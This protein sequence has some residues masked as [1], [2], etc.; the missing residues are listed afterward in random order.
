MRP[1]QFSLSS[2]P[3]K[4]LTVDVC[5]SEADLRPEGVAGLD[6][7]YIKVAG[8]LEEI[9]GKY[10]FRGTVTGA[11][12]RACDRCLVVMERTFA[13][14]VLWAF[15]EG[16]PESPWSKYDRDA[17]HEPQTEASDSSIGYYTGDELDMSPLAWE[18][19][20]LAMPAKC[21]CRDDCA[22]LCPHCGANLNE[23]QCGCS[24]RENAE[25]LRNNQFAQLLKIF[26]DIHPGMSSKEE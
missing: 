7:Q 25:D 19:V 11:Y 4:G 21:L 16:V 24:D 1:L 6:V 20:V 15:E 10:L 5:L 26:P 3:E 12:R 13:T 22:G 9:G 2:I 8:L 14:S 18:E 17:D 23:E